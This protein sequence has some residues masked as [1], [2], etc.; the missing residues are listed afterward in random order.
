VACA[1][2]INAHGSNGRNGGPP[3]LRDLDRSQRNGLIGKIE[4]YAAAR[5]CGACDHSATSS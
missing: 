3:R 1:W 5:N 2:Q 4:I